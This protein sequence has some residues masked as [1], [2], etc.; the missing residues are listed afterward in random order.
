MLKIFPSEFLTN[1]GSARG[2]R[3][4]HGNCIRANLQEVR[5]HRKS[6]INVLRT[7]AGTRDAMSNMMIALHNSAVA[8]FV[9]SAI[10]IIDA[11]AMMAKSWRAPSLAP[12]SQSSI[13]RSGCMAELKELMAQAYRWPD[14]GLVSSPVTSFAVV[15]AQWP[16]CVS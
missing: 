1:L 14:L 3:P 15:K 7:A 13:E 9:W 10:L 4:Q 5:N 2:L 11:V 16:I 8:I 12:S 6:A